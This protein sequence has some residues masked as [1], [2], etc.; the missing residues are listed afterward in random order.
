MIPGRKIVLSASRRTD[1]PAFYMDWFMACLAKGHFNVANPYNRR[2]RRVPATPDKV[3]TIVFWSKN[4]EPFIAG[5]Y[6]PVLEKRG[7]HL[8]FNF[9]LNSVSAMLEPRVPPLNARL[10]QLAW[11]CEQHHPQMVNWR[12][13]PLC[14]F[15]TN[16]GG[17][18]DNL[19]DFEAIALWA[20]RLG[21][22]RCITSFMDWYPKIQK[23]LKRSSVAVF[24]HISMDARIR[25]ITEMAHFLEPLHIELQLCCEQELLERLPAEV[26][27]VGAAC[28]PGPLIQAQFKGDIE[29]KKDSGQRRAKGCGCS[30]SVDIGSYRDHPCYHNCLFCYANPT[31]DAA[32]GRGG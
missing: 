7:F 32:P 24:R 28:I 11:I 10:K 31:A 3:D 9:T 16:R 30:V 6:G 23:R 5:G 1:I 15:E 20:A 18:G 2:I 19:G 4:F 8:F 29:L 17:A 26:K 21:I 13:D 14:F 12:F 25:T 22:R 27:A